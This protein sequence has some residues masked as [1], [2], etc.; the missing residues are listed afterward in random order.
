MSIKVDGHYWPHL[1]YM[2]QGSFRRT[3]AL[4]AEVCREVSG[5]ADYCVQS[6]IKNSGTSSCSPFREV[7]QESDDSDSEIFRVKRRSTSREEQKSSASLLNSHFSE[8][9]V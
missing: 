1:P 8:Q 2:A 9:Q 3:V 4:G 7:F 6:S 5:S